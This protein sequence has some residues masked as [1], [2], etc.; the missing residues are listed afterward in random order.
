M[1]SVLRWGNTVTN[2]SN[3]WGPGKEPQST[4]NKLNERYVK[5]PHPEDDV[6]IIIIMT[7]SEKVHS[8][9]LSL[10]DFN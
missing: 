1:D 5:V 9:S 7:L 2:N 10:G 6:V 3:K 8:C 4:V